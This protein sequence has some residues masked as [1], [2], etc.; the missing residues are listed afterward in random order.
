MVQLLEAVFRSL[1]FHL[2]CLSA[3]VAFDE[4]SLHICFEITFIFGSMDEHIHKN[5]NKNISEVTP[6]DILVV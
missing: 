5:T 4:S 2:K 6:K 3:N 1:A